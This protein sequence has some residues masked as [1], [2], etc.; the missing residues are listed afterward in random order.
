MKQPDR[1]A[2][3]VLIGLGLFVAFALTLIL[4]AKIERGAAD[5]RA[6]QIAAERSDR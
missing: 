2:A 4:G 3:Y 6:R 5:L 1:D